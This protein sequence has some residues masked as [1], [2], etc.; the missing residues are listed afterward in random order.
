MILLDTHVLLWQQLG[1]PRLGDQTRGLLQLSLQEGTAAIS[2][3]TFWEIAMRVQ[4][5]QLVFDLEL[6][7]WR[8]VLR[9]QGL[10]E[11]PVDGEIACRAG[12]LASIHGD[13]ADRIIVATALGGHK[14][15]TS[16]E[17]ILAWSKT[18]DCVDA[19]E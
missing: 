3:I 16:D 7:Y 10:V 13:P 18:L 11:I 4:K 8:N 1:D 19:R 2:A 6:Y 15:L 14:L 9:G 5:G 17:R 12:L